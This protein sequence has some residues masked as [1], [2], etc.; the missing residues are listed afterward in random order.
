[1]IAN[2]TARTDD[3]IWHRINDDIVI[4][5]DDGQSIHVLNKTAAFIWEMCDGNGGIDEIAAK[6][7]ERFDVSPEEALADIRETIEDLTKIGVL[8]YI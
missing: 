6:L 5:K 8:K 7:C 1:M 4:I 3:I 2:R